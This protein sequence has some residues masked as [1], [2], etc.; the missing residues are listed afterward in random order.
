M[1][2]PIPFFARKTA[3][4]CITQS[5][6]FL[7]LLVLISL[8]SYFS[9]CPPATNVTS[10]AQMDSALGKGKTRFRMQLR[11]E[12]VQFTFPTESNQLLSGESVVYVLSDED[13]SYVYWLAIDMPTA[14]ANQL[15]A[16]QQPMTIVCGEP[17]QKQLLAMDEA[18]KAYLT[19]DLHVTDNSFAQSMNLGYL[20]SNGGGLITNSAAIIIAKVISCLFAALALWMF[21]CLLNGIRLLF[22]NPMQHDLERFG[23]P[24]AAETALNL[25]FSS[26]DV[27]RISKCIWIQEDFLLYRDRHGASCGVFPLADVVGAYERKGFV[28]FAGIV[29]SVLVFLPDDESK[30]HTIVLKHTEAA[31]L[32]AA[33]SRRCPAA[34]LGQNAF[35]IKQWKTERSAILRRWQQRFKNYL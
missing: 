10:V 23:N 3:I 7:L 35:T 25:Q 31:E 8:L 20:S 1:N 19:E 26:P 18:M 4:A 21:I 15:L 30:P 27:L 12:Q 13:T 11:P 28:F 16:S 2:Q 29:T 14:Q 22:H 34:L 9:F 17:S 32:L 24:A 33:L 5:L 6:L